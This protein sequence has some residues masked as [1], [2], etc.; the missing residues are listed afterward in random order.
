VETEPLLPAPLEEAF[1][2]KIRNALALRT[3][4]LSRQ[5]GWAS[6]FMTREGSTGLIRV[7]IQP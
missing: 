3:I 1:R 2:R 6:G 5:R 7:N 4:F